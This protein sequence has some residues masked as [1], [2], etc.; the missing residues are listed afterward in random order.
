MNV[1]SL[2]DL[3]LPEFAYESD[4]TARC[5]GAFPMTAASGNKNTATVYVEVAPGDH[6]PTHTDSAEEVVVVLEGEA[7]VTLGAER[8]RV[9]AGSLALVPA[10][11]PHS[12][13]NVGE[14]TLRFLG[15]FSSNTVMSTFEEPLQLTDPTLAPPPSRRTILAPFPVM[16]EQDAAPAGQLEL[17]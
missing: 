16:L 2:R 7:E 13:R 5:R 3:P 6:L 12:L 17:V 10:L 9:S 11:M 4:P 14:G 15:V 8:G 1:V